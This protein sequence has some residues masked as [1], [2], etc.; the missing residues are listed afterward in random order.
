[1]RPV[2][3]VREGQSRSQEAKAHPLDGECEGL[4]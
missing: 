1:M 4:E 3:L 2:E